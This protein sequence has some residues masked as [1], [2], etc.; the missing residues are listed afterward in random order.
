VHTVDVAFTP[1]ELAGVALGGATVV[2]I[3]V[4]RASTTI[5]AALEHGAA[6]VVPVATP[7]EARR[8]ADGWPGGRALV[9]GERGG[10]PLPGFE[11]GNSPAEYRRDR[12]E[13]RTVVFTTTNGTRALLMV[14]GAA[15][16]AV[17]GFV[18]AGAVVDWVLEVPADVL[19][20]CAGESDRFCLE[21]AA[22]AGLVVDR[23][24]AALPGAPLSD[25][26]RA[27]L[28]LW[29]HYEGRLE[30]L[31]DDAVWAQRL[32]AQ[33]RGSDLP[34]CVAAD[35]SRTVPVLRDGTLVTG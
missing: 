5:I 7:A 35:S 10:A 17:G 33:G 1:S 11:C 27:A 34:L 4:V 9:A 32:A 8:R 20:V 31:L 3:D 24:R 2:V 13:G 19:L 16:A 26:A 23:L 18:N 12:V 6:A 15:R 25:A 28:I 21:D 29:R 30:R 14:E 22:C